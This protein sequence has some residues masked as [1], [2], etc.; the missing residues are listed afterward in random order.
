MRNSLLLLG[1]C[2]SLFTFQL[3]AQDQLSATQL[4]EDA[5][6]FM[7][8]T[9]ALRDAYTVDNAYRFGPS[10]ASLAK[11][12]NTNSIT[13][14]PI[15]IHIAQSGFSLSGDLFFVSYYL[16]LINQ[17]LRAANIQLYSCS[18]INVIDDSNVYGLFLSNQSVLNQYDVPNVLNLYFVDELKQGISGPFYCG[19]SSYPGQGERIIYSRRCSG[20][21][22]ESVLLHLVGQYFSLYPTHG[23]NGATPEL[24]TRTNN[25]NCTT[26][27]DELCD[28]PADPNL[29]G[30][31][32]GCTYVGTV[33]DGN[34]QAY[35]PDTG[36]Y[37]SYAPNDCRD[38]FSPQQ[39]ARM[40]YSAQFDRNYLACSQA[41]ACEVTI[42]QF[43]YTEG[44]EN[45]L[46]GWRTNSFY[47]TFTAAS[48]LVNSGATPTAGTGPN[49][50]SEGSQYIYSEA[51]LP[52]TGPFYAYPVAVI[53]S[54]CFDFSNNNSPE[55][56]FDYH[57]T[58]TGAG[59]LALQVSLDG[60]YDWNNTGH[61]FSLSGDQGNSWQNA[62][63]D[64][65]A[66]AGQ[67]WV[68]LRFVTGL[69]Q[70]D[71]GDIAV[72]AINLTDASNTCINPIDISVTD[73]DFTCGNTTGTAQLNFLLSGTPPY[74][75]TWSTGDVNVNSITMNATGTYSVTVQDAQGCQDIAVFNM[76]EISAV[77]ASATSFDCTTN[78]SQDGS[79]DLTVS[80]G[81]GPYTYNWSNGATTEDLSNVDIGFYSYTVTDANNC[82]A[83]GN[84]YVGL[85]SNCNGTKNNWP[86][87]QRFEGGVGL[88]K[89]EAV[90]DRNW[91][92][93]S[94]S[95][96]TSNTGPT[97]AAQGNY[98]RYVESSGSGNPG[99]SA[100]LTIK[101]C[102]NLT[103]VNNP[104]FEFQ[105]HMYGSTMGSLE[106]QVS[107]DGGVSWSEA[108]W[109]KSG[110]QGNQWNFASI[111]LNGYAT[112]ATRL[113]VIGVTG[114]G[115]R[116]DMAIDDAYIGPA[117]GNLLQEP[118]PQLSLSTDQLLTNGILNTIYPNP[119]NEYIN[120]EFGKALESDT[121]IQIIDRLGQ[122]LK[123]Y[124]RK[125]MA[126]T[127][128]ENIDISQLNDGIYYLRTIDQL[129]NEDSKTFIVIK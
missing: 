30:K 40:E 50:A 128:T 7:A 101:K 90:D 31:M 121:Q 52:P 110:D 32:S 117:N 87:Y 36:N 82:T 45:G 96:P 14:V 62:T 120:I 89:Q 68:I 85:A 34:G 100:I 98:Y 84:V 86:Y 6:V 67:E 88:F 91:K 13:W 44:F 4:N 63:V 78:S 81:V 113:R 64:L 59:Q 111:N 94:G 25:P 10:N 41:A 115:G 109:K 102:M 107:T 57:M 72:D 79:V 43:P 12:A 77:S 112:N 76:D 20:F 42:N 61:T 17:E 60:G 55:I 5:R 108:I 49:A 2:L 69:T 99:K 75:I 35:N 48:Y 58:G 93:R 65:S 19:L 123:Q 29:I 38:H 39:L 104:V 23:P 118:L 97:T 106:V 33:T 9:K 73:S 83:E 53:E 54:P 126:G 22:T 103:Q 26:A 8:K 124:N 37:M 56:S 46:N 18:P 127:K 92:K 71:Q 129:G 80:T 116:S 105:Y 74:Q 47:E 21:S 51:T 66:Y 15:Q 114:S 16:G 95:T 27:G 11:S 28:T 125:V 1:V 3:T 119:A 122:V 70:N 24:V